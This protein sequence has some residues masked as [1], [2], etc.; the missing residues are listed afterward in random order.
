MHSKIAN[1]IHAVLFATDLTENSP[2]ALS[3][4]AGIASRYGA[5]LFLVHVLD[6]ASETNPMDS[7]SSELRSLAQS[8]KSDLEHISKSLLAAQGVAGEVLVR[9]GNIRDVIFQ[10]RRECSADILVLGSSGKRI[11]RGQGLGSIAEAVLRGM[12]CSVVTVGPHV[13]LPPFSGKAQAILFLTDFSATSLAALP[14]ATSF[15][16]NL[17]VSLILLHVCD[18]YEVHSSSGHEAVC[19]KKLGEIARFVE[20]EGVPVEEFVR[21]GHV[22]EK[23]L[24]FAKEKNVDFIVMGVHHGDLADG[25]RLH[26]VVSDL[27]REAHCPVFTVAQQVAAYSRES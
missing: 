4:A 12:P 13:E 15:A 14:A 7:S 21:E 5:R 19:R 20:N 8:A 27:V 26:G 24:A 6:P 25:T 10:V 23:V 17:S 1:P 11:G 22:A 16:V 9:Y 2:V 18:P 3:Y